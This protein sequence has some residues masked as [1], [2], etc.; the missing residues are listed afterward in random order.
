MEQHPNLSRPG[1]ALPI[2]PCSKA[3]LIFLRFFAQLATAQRQSADGNGHNLQLVCS[4]M[5]MLGKLAL[6]YRLGCP[7]LGSTSADAARLAMR[8]KNKNEKP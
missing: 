8:Q 1:R 2:A 6:S 3:G 5:L 7:P 4:T